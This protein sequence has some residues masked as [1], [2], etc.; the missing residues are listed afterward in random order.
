VQPIESLLD[1][2]QAAVVQIRPSGAGVV[3][4]QGGRI[5]I[6]TN[7]HVAR[8]SPGALIQVVTWSGAV[9]DS[10]VERIDSHRDLAVLIPETGGS[11][12]DG[13]QPAVPGD[14]AALRPGHL[15]LAVG[16][17][18]GLANAV[19]TGV[20]HSIGPLRAGFELPAGRGDLQWI[21]A[22][23]RLAPGNSGGPLCDA[24]G[25]VIGINTMVVNGLGL[26]VPITDVM[27]FT[28]ASPVRPRRAGRE[29][30]GVR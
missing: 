18:F 28:Q 1:K 4:E 21:Q 8:S 11:R 3:F 26:A 22:D 30:V 13:L 29:P 24:Q 7:A 12:L 20:V 10:R 14:I 6:V 23:V 15:A 27:Q 2:I 9:L 5:I 17:P 16:H 25:R 19:S